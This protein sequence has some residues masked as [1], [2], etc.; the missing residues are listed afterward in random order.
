MIIVGVARTTAQEVVVAAA[1]RQAVIIVGVAPVQEV[2]VVGPEVGV[3]TMLV[4]RMGMII[5]KG[6]AVGTKRVEV[7]KAA[8]VRMR[9]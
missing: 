3:A 5:R 4:I 6:V 2:M 8:K 1:T 9:S 7:T